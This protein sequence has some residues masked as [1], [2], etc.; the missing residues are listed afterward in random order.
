MRITLK[1]RYALRAVLAL[2]EMGKDGEMVSINSLSEAEEISSI[3]L[4][5]IFFKLKKAHIVKSVRGPG[6]GFAFDRPLDSISVQ[7]ILDAAGEE[8]SMKF[9]DKNVEDCSRMTECISHKVFVSVSDKIDEYLRSLTL[10]KI[11][12]SK[13]FKPGRG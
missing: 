2:A 13:E 5:Q 11:L 4:E 12:E 10:K 7:E 1:G 6:G 3:F 9:C 8:L